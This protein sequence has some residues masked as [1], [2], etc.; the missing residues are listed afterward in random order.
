MC[1]VARSSIGRR[2]NRMDSSRSRD[3][4]RD[5]NGAV[6]TTRARARARV[7]WSD[8]SDSSIPGIASTA[9]GSQTPRASIRA[10][11]TLCCWTARRNDRA[12]MV[13]IANPSRGVVPATRGLDP[14]PRDPP[15][16]GSCAT[17]VLTVNR[18]GRSTPLYKTRLSEARPRVNRQNAVRSD[19]RS[20]RTIARS[21]HFVIVVSSSPPSVGTRLRARRSATVCGSWSGSIGFRKMGPGMMGPGMI[22]FMMIGRD[23]KQRAE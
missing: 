20:R 17:T 21:I 2:V 4:T 3:A 23:L 15:A 8:S 14:D 12:S 22:D 10:N 18:I 19:A 7:R 9:T 13:S 6:R 11:H 16:T 1:R 5:D